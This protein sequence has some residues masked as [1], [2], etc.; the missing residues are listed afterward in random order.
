MGHGGV[1]KN[2]STAE[3]GLG[4]P[5]WT[6]EAGKLGRGAGWDAWDRGTLEAGPGSEWWG[7]T[8]VRAIL[9]PHPPPS[10]VSVYLMTSSGRRHTAQ[11]AQVM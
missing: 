4:G 2:Q 5:S 8:R 3:V 1:A 11:R 7:R 9:G 6:G 10:P